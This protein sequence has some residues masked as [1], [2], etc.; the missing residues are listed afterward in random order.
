MPTF[1]QQYTHAR[2]AIEGGDWALRAEIADL[3]AQISDAKSIIAEKNAAILE[4]KRNKGIDEMTARIEK[5]EKALTNIALACNVE[6][7]SINDG[8]YEIA[9]IIETLTNIENNAD[10]ARNA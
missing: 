5:F 2:A 6:I 10:E 9:E 1:D 4:L 3:Q 8:E 7:A